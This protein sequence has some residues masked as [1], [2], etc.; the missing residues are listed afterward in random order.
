MKK[1]TPSSSQGSE[2]LEQEQAQSKVLV[3]KIS[4]VLFSKEV[5]ERQE[6]ILGVL[7]A[8]KVFNKF[9]NHFKGRGARFE[10]ALA[11]AKRMRQLAV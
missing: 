6:R 10:T 4:E 2:L 11:R 5:L 8:E 1:L 7:K 9:Q 3:Q